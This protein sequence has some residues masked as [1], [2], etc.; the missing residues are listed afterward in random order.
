VLSVQ[1]STC[2]GPSNVR[3][4]CYGRF[5][6]EGSHSPTTPKWQRVE[7]I[8]QEYLGAHASPDDDGDKV[9]LSWPV[10]ANWLE[11][12]KEALE[13]ETRE[14][15]FLDRPDPVV[16]PVPSIPVMEDP[17][18]LDAELRR[19]A[20]LRTRW[21]ELIAWQANDHTVEQWIERASATTCIALRKEIDEQEEAQISARGHLDLRMPARV[22]AT[23]RD[24]IRAVRKDAGKC[25]AH[26]LHGVHDGLIRVSGKAPDQLC[27]EL[28]SSPNDAPGWGNA[29]GVD[30]IRNAA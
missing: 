12:L 18:L 6:S 27:W 9:I 10:T 19:L 16:A 17:V 30:R 5:V 24:A 4:A 28:T 13:K 8:C 22:A 20:A 14:W 29:A 2:G 25:A 1:P 26:H 21:D 7:V 15:E 11:E 3:G 23:L